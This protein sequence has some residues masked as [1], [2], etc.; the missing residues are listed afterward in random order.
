MS[1]NMFG[2]GHASKS[3]ACCRV[4]CRSSCLFPPP[5]INQPPTQG[6]GGVRRRGGEHP[7]C[8]HRHRHTVGPTLHFA[9]LTDVSGPG[10]P[11]HRVHTKRGFKM[12]VQC[13]HSKLDP[14]SRWHITPG[15]HH[16]HA[17]NVFLGPSKHHLVSATV[18]WTET[19]LWLRS[20]VWQPF[21]PYRSKRGR[22]IYSIL[23]FVRGL[24]LLGL[25]NEGAIWRIAGAYITPP[26][27][28]STHP[29]AA[30]VS[31]HEEVI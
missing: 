9:L 10:L 12:R 24:D 8:R 3:K 17:P 23:Y 1:G 15:H 28:S 21:F 19:A 22:L 18:A 30:I 7:P 4:L 2:Q 13:Q 16:V 5:A 6:E 27:S 26:S 11:V 14:R 31:E 25:S 20:V 29:A